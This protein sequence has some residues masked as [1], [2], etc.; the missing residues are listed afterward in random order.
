LLSDTVSTLPVDVF[1]EGSRDP[2]PLPPLLRQPGAGANLSE[3][4][5]QAMVSLLLRG[6]SY[7]LITA[8]SG[9]SMRPSQVELVHPDLVT[10]TVMPD[11][12]VEKR[13]RGEVVTP[14]QLWHVRAFT[15]PGL[16]AGLSPVTYARQ[17]IGLGLATQRFGNQFFEEGAAPSGV[18]TAEGRLT[19]NQVDEAKRRFMQ[20]HRGKREPLVLGEGITWKQISVSPTDAA[21]VESQQFTVGDVARLYN[22]PAEMVG[23]E[24]G[25]SMTY[26]NIE[27]RDLSFMKYA[28]GPWLVRFERALGE[29]LPRGQFVKFNPNALLRAT[30]KQRFD[31]YKVALDAKFMTV[32]EVRALEDLPPLA[33]GGIA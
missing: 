16:P 5:Y 9:S 10:C 13:Y 14:D 17:T 11:G 1:R 2:L 22:I 18:L 28:V 31:A 6:N 25:D 32:D 4:L 26:A 21:W 19:Q 29:L 23:G 8:R 12:R 3:W 15:F 27:G 24:S 33:Q 20:S 30:T 7:G